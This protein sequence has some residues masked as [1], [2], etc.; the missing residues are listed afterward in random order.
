MRTNDEWIDFP[1]K[2]RIGCSHPEKKLVNVEG[3]PGV[4]KFTCSK[5]EENLIIFESRIKVT[6]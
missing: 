4:Y 2:P 3:E 6:P 5:C 1:V